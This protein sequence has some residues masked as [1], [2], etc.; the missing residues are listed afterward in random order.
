M[1]GMGPF[2]MNEFKWNVLGTIFLVGFAASLMQ[3][4]CLLVLTFDCHVRHVDPD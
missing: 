3:I 2:C 4:Y 1:R